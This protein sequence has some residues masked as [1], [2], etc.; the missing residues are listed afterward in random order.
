MVVACSISTFLHEALMK[1]ALHHQ[2]AI[3]ISAAYLP[4]LFQHNDPNYTRIL[5]PPIKSSNHHPIRCGYTVVSMP[6]ATVISQQLLV[7]I[8]NVI[9][10]STD[11]PSA[12][13]DEL[14]IRN[15]QQSLSHSPFR[16]HSPSV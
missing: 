11:S 2:Q 8:K 3:M 15:S 6:T 16:T 1:A 12:H 4:S 9:T 13:S 7:I 10:V 14:T 5:A